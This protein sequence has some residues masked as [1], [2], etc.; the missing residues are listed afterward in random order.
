MR[1]EGRMVRDARLIGRVLPDLNPLVHTCA[2]VSQL[3]DLTN[4]RNKRAKTQS[5][6]SVM[7]LCS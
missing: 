2:F 1:G 6:R 7:R 3:A 4:S 5:I